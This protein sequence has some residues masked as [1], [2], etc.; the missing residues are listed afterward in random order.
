MLTTSD[1]YLAHDTV[2][3]GDYQASMLLLSLGIRTTFNL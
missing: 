1:P 2:N 3:D